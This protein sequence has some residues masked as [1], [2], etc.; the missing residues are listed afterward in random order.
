MGNRTTITPTDANAATS[1]TRA[2]LSGAAPA[3]NSRADLQTALG[4]SLG[5]TVVWIPVLASEPR[6]V[7]LDRE[8][9]RNVLA[10]QLRDC[11]SHS[12]RPGRGQT[13]SGNGRCD[14]ACEEELSEMILESIE[15]GSQASLF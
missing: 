4:P 1:R 2:T 3:S 8:R 11:P 7:V 14:L 10:K 15:K 5:Q 6:E 13:R 12:Q 9:I